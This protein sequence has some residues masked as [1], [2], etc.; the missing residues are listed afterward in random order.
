MSEQLCS[1]GQ[2]E[3]QMTG[4]TGLMECEIKDDTSPLLGDEAQPGQRDME[5]D[6]IN[7]AHEDESNIDDKDINAPVGGVAQDAVAN[8]PSGAAT[9][10]VVDD[11][12]DEG[13]EGAAA[14]CH[15]DQDELPERAPRSH[16]AA[17]SPTV[18]AGSRR[19]MECSQAP[20]SSTL[21]EAESEKGNEKGTP[22][23]RAVPEDADAAQ[24]QQREKKRNSKSAA[25]TS[26]KEK[27]LEASCS[28]AQGSEDELG[29]DQPRNEKA[30]GACAV[31]WIVLAGMAV[32]AGIALA[33]CFC[34]G[35]LNTGEDQRQLFN[36]GGDSYLGG[37]FPALDPEGQK[38]RPPV[39]S[40]EEAV[41]WPLVVMSRDRKH[42]TASEWRQGF[43]LQLNVGSSSTGSLANAA[44]ALKNHTFLLDTG[45]GANSYFLL[46]PTDDRPAFESGS[47]E[48]LPV[49]ETHHARVHR[50]RDAQIQNDPQE[51]AEGPLVTCKYGDGEVEGRALR[52]TVS[53]LDK[54]R[55]PPPEHPVWT[56]NKHR[57][58]NVA[59]PT[60][61]IAGLSPA[62]DGGHDAGTAG[63][64]FVIRLGRQ[65][66]R[67]HFA[68]QPGKLPLMYTQK[69]KTPGNLGLGFAMDRAQA[70]WFDRL[71]SL[72]DYFYLHHLAVTWE[73]QQAQKSKERA[74]V[75]SLQ[76]TDVNGRWLQEENLNEDRDDTAAS[77]ENNQNREQRGGE[78]LAQEIVH[79]Q[80]EQGDGV[81]TGLDHNSGSSSVVDGDGHLPPEGTQRISKNRAAVQHLPPAQQQRE[82][83]HAQQEEERLRLVLGASPAFETLRR[84]PLLQ[85]VQVN[86]VGR[87]PLRTVVLEALEQIEAVQKVV[88]YVVLMDEYDR[89]LQWVESRNDRAPGSAA[90]A[91]LA[92]LLR[93]Q[94]K[95]RLTPAVRSLVSRFER[96]GDSAAD[97][98]NETFIP[99]NARLQQ[100]TLLERQ[101]QLREV[102]RM[103]V[104]VLARHDEDDPLTPSV[105]RDSPS[106]ASA[107]LADKLRIRPIAPLP[108][109]WPTTNADMPWRRLPGVYPM[110]YHQ[111]HPP[112]V[113][114]H[115]GFPAARVQNAVDLDSHHWTL[116][117]L[118]IKI[119]DHIFDPNDL[120]AAYAAEMRPAFLNPVLQ[121]SG[122]EEFFHRTRNPSGGQPDH[123]GS[124]NVEEPP[125]ESMTAWYST[126]DKVIQ[127]LRE[128]DGGG[129]A[130]KKAYK[131]V[132]DTGWTM[133]SLAP[134]LFRA[135]EDHFTSDVIASGRANKNQAKALLQQEN[136]TVQ[137][138]DQLRRP[139][140]TN[141]TP[142]VDGGEVVEVVP[143]DQSEDGPA[144]AE[145]PASSTVVYSVYRE[146]MKNSL[147]PQQ[148]SKDPAAESMLNG[149]VPVPQE[150]AH[151]VNVELRGRTR[152]RTPPQMFL[153]QAGTRGENNNI[154]PERK[155][156]SE[157]PEISIEFPVE[158][159]AP[160]ASRSAGGAAAVGA[161]TSKALET[162]WYTLRPRDYCYCEGI[163]VST[164]SGK[165]KALHHCLEEYSTPDHRGGQAARNANRGSTAIMLG[166]PFHR[167]FY[168]GYQFADKKGIL[169][170]NMQ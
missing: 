105:S 14:A 156:C 57:Y 110:R 46:K 76:L 103:V 36:E 31:F 168:V 140:T 99:T 65:Y 97:I 18:T 83:Q 150:R 30:C 23:V 56:Q 63:G 72:L 154:K 40:N 55:L 60:S 115:L 141:L 81:M 117:A 21:L 86:A 144:G 159:A 114:P 100:R 39:V 89:G 50:S 33:V 163:N 62:Q 170:P 17:Y 6:G 42:A 2:G 108:D 147:V 79:E 20:G 87:L 167:S 16:A 96:L 49:P 38:R 109:N 102:L 26:G 155:P 34:T 88:K 51:P 67:R 54:L 120:E 166:I 4:Q 92:D 93:V 104:E 160:V 169:L 129:R 145:E 37:K 152:T 90:P 8:V 123:P 45:G 133:L 112:P 143:H 107:A 127:N 68:D 116:P 161:T 130:A 153:Q 29:D 77:D 15:Q 151:H 48:L 121:W 131:C 132:L 70:E 82:Q 12:H 7:N 146:L 122:G 13:Q 111:P 80:E 94:L 125:K 91:W 52:D 69:W 124:T 134:P 149:T 66:D 1:H 128:A 98:Y 9:A 113:F 11:F 53:I 162:S 157:G 5:C 44:P 126:K 35:L 136:A 73:A 138:V 25:S 64:D 101:E 158:S 142:K 75:F 43:G 95:D 58:T 41:Q 139:P 165:V 71:P 22:G 137:Q 27:E 164:A 148:G 118:R 119:G 78:E 47:R 61:P 10:V 3:G 24:R 59:A 85:E 74:I 106:G 28:F 84:V 19:K 32:L 135:F